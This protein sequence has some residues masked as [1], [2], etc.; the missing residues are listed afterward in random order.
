MQATFLRQ[1]LEALSAA[2]VAPARSL[3]GSGGP[4]DFDALISAACD[5]HDVDPML[6]KAL[7]KAESGFNPDA[8]SVAGAKGLMQLMDATAASLGVTDSFDP[9]QN[10]EAGVRFLGSMLRRYQDE[11][12]ALAAY[13]AGPGAVDKHGGIPPFAE[14]QVYVPRVLAY[15]DQLGAPGHWEA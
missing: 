9:A 1:A 13:N 8:V 12:L 7:I 5:R 2:G 4:G 14:T 11:A 10:I 6:V 15:R 3:A